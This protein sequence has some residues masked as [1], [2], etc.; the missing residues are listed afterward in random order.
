M[1]G[2]APEP[3]GLALGAEHAVRGIET[4]ELGIGGGIDRRID[5]DDGVGTIA[6]I[7]DQVGPLH[8]P[9][10]PAFAIDAHRERSQ[11]VTAQR[12]RC[13]RIGM[14][15]DRQRRTDARRIEAEREIE[16]DVGYLPFG[17]AIIAAV[18]GDGRNG[19][20]R[21]VGHNGGLGLRRA[22]RNKGG[23]G[24]YAD[25]RNGLCGGP[26]RR[27]V[28]RARVGGER[29]DARRTRRQHRL[30]RR[31]RG[32]GR[33]AIGDAYP[34]VGCPRRTAPTRCLPA[35]ARR[36]RSHRQAGPDISPRQAS[37]AIPAARGS[38]KAHR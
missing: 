29:D 6:E 19:G 18:D 2:D 4:H 33:A 36:W 11:T 26:Y 13:R 21:S 24:T 8:V 28:A 38:T 35:M 37:M 31:G 5:L 30:R 23:D 3:L 27:P 12:Q 22:P 20:G 17:R 10:V 14:A 25:F 34:V 15:H 9:I 16:R 7:D 1:E 32:A